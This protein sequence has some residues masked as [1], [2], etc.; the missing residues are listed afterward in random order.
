MG[1]DA[2]AGAGGGAGENGRFAKRTVSVGHRL[3]VP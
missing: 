3:S 1:E 2:G